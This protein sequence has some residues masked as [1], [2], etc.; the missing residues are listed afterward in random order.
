[1]GGIRISAPSNSW[2][3]ASPVWLELPF[4]GSI[5]GNLGAT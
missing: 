2:K 5:G 1:L 4:T 3:S